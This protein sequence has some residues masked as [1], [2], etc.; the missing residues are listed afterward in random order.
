MHEIQR[1]KTWLNYLR[2]QLEDG[3]EYYNKDRSLSRSS[4]YISVFYDCGFKFNTYFYLKDFH[5][6]MYQE[7]D[8]VVIGI[9][10][11]QSL[12]TSIF[13]VDGVFKYPSL[14]RECIR[15]FFKFYNPDKLT[16]DETEHYVYHPDEFK[17]SKYYE[18][19][20]D[21]KDRLVQSNITFKLKDKVYK[22]YKRRDI[23]PVVV[24]DFKTLTL[25]YV[26]RKGNSAT[27]SSAGSARTYE[28]FERQGGESC[29][30][31]NFKLGNIVA[32]IVGRTSLN[33]HFVDYTG[34][35]V[36]GEDKVRS[37]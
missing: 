9:P 22:T 13:L 21:E 6:E 19:L 37:I 4:D 14:T 11:N 28:T 15:D 1:N 33:W 10:L 34:L 17:N 30:I 3:L 23:L 26:R 20:L 35:L 25:F 16:S 5:L 36:D 31:G 8:E 18:H 7:G 12:Y 27:V 2:K 24:V 29:M 32:C